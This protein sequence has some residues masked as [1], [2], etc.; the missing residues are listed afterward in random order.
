MMRP[1]HRL[2]VLA[3]PAFADVAPVD[4]LRR[5]VSE[6]LNEGVIDARGRPGP[7][8]ARWMPEG[9]RGLR[10]D[11]PDRV[12]LYGNRQGGFRVHCPVDDAIVTEAFS[13]AYSQ[14]R[15]TRRPDLGT[16]VCPSCGATHRLD[17]MVGKPPFRFARTALQTIDAEALHP[18]AAMIERLERTV[19]EVAWVGIRV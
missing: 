10:L 18:T 14:V 12:T 1:S 16:F 17:E 2:D 11:L 5:F 6:L 13:R 4:G 7:L 15:S 8:F 3:V 19:G 9:F